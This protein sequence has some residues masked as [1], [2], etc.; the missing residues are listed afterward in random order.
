[1]LQQLFCHRDILFA[2]A[3]ILVC[4]LA[5]FLAKGEEC[6]EGHGYD[7]ATQTCFQCEAGTYMSYENT[8]ED[9][10][11]SMGCR[12]C[13]AGEFS[14]AAASSCSTCPAGK[15]SWAQSTACS[16]CEA[17]KFSP[18]GVRDCI[19]C[20]PGHFASAVGTSECLKCPAGTFASSYS[21][22]TSCT[23]C[24]TGYWSETG[25]KRCTA[26]TN[27]E[28]LDE[29]KTCSTCPAGTF[30]IQGATLEPGANKLSTSH[31]YSMFSSLPNYSNNQSDV[32]HLV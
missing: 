10:T 3:M 8:T 20:P 5:L 4:A 18:A 17:G 14:E 23:N 1:M 21:G 26:C 32:S 19:L 15:Y 30:S 11:F 12:P 31:H 27:G 7:T 9:L 29:N 2:C 22:A 13:P 25:S 16:L 28:F 24:P 6:P